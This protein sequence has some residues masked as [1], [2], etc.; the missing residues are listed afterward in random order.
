MRTVRSHATRL[1]QSVA[2]RILVVDDEPAVRLFLERVLH[3]AGYAVVAA[4]GGEE[5]LQLI[6]DGPEF[7]LILSDVRMPRM[8]G[9][10]FIE[11]VRQER[12]DVSVLFLTGYNDQLFKEK[13]AL[14][15]N[16]AFL[17][18]PA[19]VKGLLEAVSLLVCG[20]LIPE[21]SVP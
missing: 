3:D 10:Q 11:R 6:Q 13:V 8:S 12:P 17:D 19:S 20:H 21:Q 14:S 15:N 7:D 1:K 16:E 9:P 5:A 2:P 18:K 4:S